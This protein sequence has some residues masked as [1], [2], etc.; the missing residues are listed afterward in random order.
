[1]TQKDYLTKLE[2][3]KTK[4]G[5]SLNVY[6]GYTILHIDILL[7]GKTV[8][9][10]TISEDSPNKFKICTTKENFCN[11]K[12]DKKIIKTILN[13]SKYLK[14]D[15]I[16]GRINIDNNCCEKMFNELNFLFTEQFDKRNRTAKIIY[17]L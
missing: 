11:D 7:N 1:M 16:Y 9:W 3:F 5:I 15:E 14:I 4:K 8:V 2:H 17:N 6:E 12:E 13:V 10:C